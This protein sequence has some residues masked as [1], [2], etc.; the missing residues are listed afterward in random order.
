MECVFPSVKKDGL[1]VNDDAMIEMK[2]FLMKPVVAF[3]I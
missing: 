1:K 3:Y 2:Y